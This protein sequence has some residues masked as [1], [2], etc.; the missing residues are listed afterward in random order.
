[1]GRGFFLQREHDL[2]LDNKMPGPVSPKTNRTLIANQF[3][4]AKMDCYS[5]KG[6]VWIRPERFQ[7]SVCQELI[8]IAQQEKREISNYR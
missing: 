3:T 5:E 8:V 7:A 2:A 4:N 1:M 6:L